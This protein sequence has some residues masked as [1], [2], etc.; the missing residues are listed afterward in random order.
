LSLLAQARRTRPLP[1]HRPRQQSEAREGARQARE[2]PHLGAVPP[3]TVEADDAGE[4]VRV[5]DVFD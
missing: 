4:R 5:E 3:L 2:R 1:H